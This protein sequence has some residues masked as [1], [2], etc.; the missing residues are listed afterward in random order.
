MKKI[1]FI[2]IAMSL[3]FTKEVSAQQIDP[4]LAAVVE[5]QTETLKD[6]YKKRNSTQEMLIATQAGVAAAMKSIHDVEN[7]VLEYMRNASAAL[8]N[9]YQLKQA[10]ELVGEKIP[11]QMKK[12]VTAVP[13]NWEGT[14]VTT[15][16]SKTCA[17]V[18]TEMASLYGFMNELVTSSQYSLGSGKDANSGKKNIN[19]LSAAE[20]YYIANEVVYKLQTIYR[21]LW[22]I[23]WQIENLDWS[24]ALRNLDPATWA[25]LN[26][27][28]AVSQR[29]IKQ[30][31]KA[32]PFK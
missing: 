21:K 14:A 20:R 1:L 2:A 4:G 29:L 31:Q 22:Y 13:K 23:T 27:G 11:T 28:K 25:Q 9:I 18:A 7:K 32:T 19:L 16:T 24:D 5:I 26:S 3:F 10:A 12:M 6:A 30:W 17:S 15:L 8:D